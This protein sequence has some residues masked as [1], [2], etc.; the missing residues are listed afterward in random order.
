MLRGKIFNKEEKEIYTA[1]KI[2]FRDEI[3]VC[4]KKNEI[5]KFSF[6][7]LIWLECTG[8]TAQGKYIYNKDFIIAK[9]GEEVITGVVQR[10][11][12]MWVVENK[13]KGSSRTLK[14]LKEDG[15]E[16]INLQNAI[17]YFKNKRNKEKI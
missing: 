5:F 6:S 14:N 8:Y 1:L 3:V 15:F 7:K 9:K 17:A 11:N 16:F 12:K 10:K 2:N 4:R 13:P